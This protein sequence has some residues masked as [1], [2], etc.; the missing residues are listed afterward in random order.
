MIYLRH[1]IIEKNKEAV[2][3]TDEGEFPIWI[4]DFEKHFQNLE[5]GEEIENS[6]LL[7]TLAIRR[8]IKKKA[9]R[10]LAAGDITR[11]ELTRKLL[12]EKVYGGNADPEWVEELL[13]K[14]ENAGYID[15]N[16]YALRFMEKSLDKFWGI[17]RIRAA[18][19]EKGFTD[20]HIDGALEK[21][22]PDFVGMAKEYIEKNLNGCDRNTVYKKMYQRGYISEE[23]IEAID[24]LNIEN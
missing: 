4:R 5:K 2:I 22:S 17:M 9:I 24:A 12:R 11:R 18:M 13:A 3:V 20:E 14:L 16:G 19:R 8:E 1:Y 7:V 21:L 15:D 23:I 10:R 6:E